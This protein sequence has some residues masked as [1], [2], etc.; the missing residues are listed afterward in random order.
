[1]KLKEVGTKIAALRK[2]KQITQKNI[3]DK[4]HVTTVAVSKWE[5]GIN[6]PN[7]EQVEKLADILETTPAEL[8]GLETASANDI[9]NDISQIAMLEVKRQKRKTKIVGMFFVAAIVLIIFSTAIIKFTNYAWTSQYR[10]GIYHQPFAGYLDESGLTKLGSV[11]NC[12]IYMYN[13]DSLTYQNW[14]AERVDMRDVLNESWASKE[15]IF[16]KDGETKMEL[17]NNY[18]IRVNHYEALITLDT[19]GAIIFMHYTDSPSEAL[20]ALVEKHSQEKL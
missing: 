20:E 4:L 18:P 8:M 17:I 5:R 3:A 16:P 12:D 15:S 11:D 1:M 14:K 6:Y 9:I 7:M 13:M 10:H 2:E 19:G